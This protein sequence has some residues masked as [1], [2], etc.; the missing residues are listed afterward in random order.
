MKRV[1]LSV[2]L[3]DLRLEPKTAMDRARGM[4]FRAIDVSAVAGPLSPEALSQTGRRHLL[5]HLSDLGLRLSSLRGPAGGG[6]YSDSLA[7]ERRLESMRKVMDLAA[8]LRVPIVSTTLGTVANVAPEEGAERTREA[9]SILAD[10]ADR[11]G[12]LV[13]IES[14]GVATAELRALLEQINCPQ[15]AACCDS[16]AMLM[17]GDDPHAIAETLAGRVRLVR[18]RDAVPGTPQAAGHEVAFG[19]GH[20]DAPRFL[21]ALAQAGFDGD[22]I[23]TRTSGNRPTEELE[24]AREAFDKLLRR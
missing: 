14:M 21:A 11:K 8:A 19:E 13:T 16:G 24:K 5:K 6:A 17:Q 23:L 7:G 20:L 10:D 18:A 22:L 4:G 1:E 3:D 2:C 15:L 9:L 12:I